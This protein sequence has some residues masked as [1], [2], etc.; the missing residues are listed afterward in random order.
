M[1]VH[2]PDTG[3]NRHKQVATSAATETAEV[4][5]LFVTF[6]AVGGH[7]VRYTAPFDVEWEGAV[8][9]AHAAEFARGWFQAAV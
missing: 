2:V 8:A 6:S 5:A 1:H 3:P 4:L 9:E 7:P